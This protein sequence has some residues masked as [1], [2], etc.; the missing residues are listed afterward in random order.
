MD[1]HLYLNQ[2]ETMMDI[3]TAKTLQPG[4]RVR[5][6][7]VPNHAKMPFGRDLNHW[8]FKVGDEA[9]LLQLDTTDEFADW[10]AKFDDDGK[11]WW[12]ELRFGVDFEV[13]DG[14]VETTR[15]GV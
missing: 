15:T 4:M 14:E 6:T 5:I 9:T 11:S 1:G 2:E 10:Y 13:L 7:A 3:E 12:L 8:F